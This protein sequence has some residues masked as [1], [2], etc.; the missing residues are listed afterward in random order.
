MSRL[1]LLLIHFPLLLFLASCAS[2]YE[3]LQE[4]TPTPFN[5]KPL[6]EW[7]EPFTAA[8]ADPQLKEQKVLSKKILIKP[9][10]LSYLNPSP[11]EGSRKKK[12]ADRLSLY[13]DQHLAEKIKNS[14]VASSRITNSESS[15]DF[16]MEPAL[17]QLNPTRYGLNFISFGTSLFI[18]MV[19]YAFTPF[20]YGEMT[21]MVKIYDRRHKNKVYAVFAD[22]KRDEPTVFGSIRDFT[23]YGHHYK[24]MDAWAEMMTQLLSS[25]PGERLEKPKWITLN[26]F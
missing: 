5:D 19:S 14:P 26:P 11:E 23:A 1:Y 16:V 25:Q 7:E 6:T 22:Y 2:D 13:F 9:L 10:T 15:A 4:A 18:P 24:T 8:W 12:W 20:T 3:R 17:I 21:M